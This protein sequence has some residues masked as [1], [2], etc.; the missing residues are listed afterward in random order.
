[1]PP[2]FP[3][4]WSAA[5]VVPFTA[6]VASVTLPASTTNLRHQLT[7]LHA[8]VINTS[9]GA[10]NDT[11][12]VFDGGTQ[13]WS[14]VLRTDSTAGGSFDEYDTDLTLTGSPN[15]AMTFRINNAGSANV[16][17]EISGTGRDL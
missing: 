7:H 8:R 1:M 17:V 6:T 2:P 13:I 15:T 14:W 12:Q 3:P 10:R 16:C 11:L 4:E 9:G 5:S